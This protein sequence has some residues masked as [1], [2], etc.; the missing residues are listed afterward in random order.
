MT[1]AAAGGDGDSPD[2]CTPWRCCQC[3]WAEGPQNL[4]G[5]PVLPVSSD[6]LLVQGQLSPSSASQTPP[7]TRLISHGRGRGEGDTVL[8]PVP[9]PWLFCPAARGAAP[10]RDPGAR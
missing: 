1:S 5:R 4:P 7:P 2:P 6:P 9:V 10:A 8:V 3:W